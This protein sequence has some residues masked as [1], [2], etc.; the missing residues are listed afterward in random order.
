MSVTSCSL[1]AKK[2]REINVST[3]PMEKPTL[4]LPSVGT[5]TMEDVSWMIITPE[6][7]ET[8]FIELEDRGRNGVAFSLSGDD[9]ESLSRNMAQ[10]MKLVQQQR[11]QIRAYKQYYT[12][13]EKTM[14]EK[15]K[16]LS[17]TDQE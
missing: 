17:T 3:T 9:Y 1:F 14:D 13:A 10:I 8:V 11:V 4:I 15:N 12:E 5:L 16:E 2:D 7:V 6:N